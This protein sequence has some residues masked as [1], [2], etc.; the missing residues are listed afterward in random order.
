MR[1]TVSVLAARGE[2]G[3]I[4][5]L[6]VIVLHLVS[7]SSRTSGFLNLVLD[8]AAQVSVVDSLFA[9]VFTTV[10]Y[11]DFVPGFDAASCSPFSSPTSEFRSSRRVVSMLVEALA[12]QERP[13]RGCCT[14]TSTSR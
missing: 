14:M 1:S 4:S 11:G 10:G 5:Q 9:V 2:W 7:A 8:A 13:S 12:S 3:R 6:V